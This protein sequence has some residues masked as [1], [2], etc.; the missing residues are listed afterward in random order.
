MNGNPPKFYTSDV[1]RWF[2]Q[3]GG[4]DKS[5][6]EKPALT[7]DMKR[8]CITWCNDMKDL[9]KEHCN[10]CYVCF[11]NK[12]HWV[13][14]D[15]PIYLFLD[16]AGSHGANEAVDKYVEMLNNDYGAICIHQPPRSPAT[17]MIDLRVWM[18][19]Q[20]VVKNLHFHQVYEI[21]ALCNTTT[22]AWNNLDAVKLKN[23]F[24]RWK[25]VL[26]LILKDNGGDR[27]I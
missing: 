26:N 14:L 25:M 16:N 27:Y 15:V 17:N 18:D 5:P 2:K 24:E 22:K 13:E 21:M 6:K 11:L 9:I 19:L 23:V 8:R 3:L 20:S 12:H 7:L 4:K 10:E 1:Y